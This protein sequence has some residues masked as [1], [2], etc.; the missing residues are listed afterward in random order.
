MYVT[1][2]GVPVMLSGVTFTSNSDA[3][4]TDG[5]AVHPVG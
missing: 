4:L 3:G 1:Q 2:A 5:V